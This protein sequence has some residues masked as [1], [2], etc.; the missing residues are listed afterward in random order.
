MEIIYEQ[1][2]TEMSFYE[3]TWH[4]GVTAFHWHER[5][6]IVLPQEHPIGALI[7]GVWYEAKKGDI[8]MIGEEKIHAFR[9]E[10]ENV[11][12]L[13]GQFPYR[14]LLGNGN[15]P[16]TIRPLITAEEIAAVPGLS[17]RIGALLD[18]LLAERKVENGEKNPVLQSVSVALYYLLLRHFPAAREPKNEKKEKGE[19]YRIVSYVDEHYTDNITVGSIAHE[20]YIDRGKLSRLFLTYAGM[21]L[22]AYI[23][24]L[25]IDRASALIMGGTPITE[26]AL[27]SGFQSVRTFH[28]V[29]RRMKGASPRELKGTK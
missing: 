17:E 23:N 1:S 28:E 8:I 25:R 19:F 26:A 6:E 2:R 20:L 29:Y 3:G 16:G 27:D 9:M 18:V 10:E 24:S 21:P 11:P 13:L 5:L 12:F 4:R 14:I 7:D 22:N 15:E